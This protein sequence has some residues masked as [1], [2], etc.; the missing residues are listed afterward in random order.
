[1]QQP[2]D[3]QHHPLLLA[4][5]K[6]GLAAPED[7]APLSDR[8]RDRDDVYALKCARSG[9][10]V[11]NRTDHINAEVYE[12]RGDLSY[13]GPAERAKLLQSTLMDDA[14]RAQFIRPHVQGKSYLDIGTG[15]GGILDIVRPF[16]DEVH[17][18]EPQAGARDILLKEGYATFKHI[19]D[20]PRQHYDVV[21][22]L[23]V[24]EHVPDQIEFLASVRE[25]LKPGG[26]L[27]VEVPHARDALLSLYESPAFLNFT[28]WS[29][30]L[31]LHTRESL[32]R[33]AEQAAFSDIQVRG[34][35]RYSLANHLHWLAKNKPGGHVVWDFLNDDALSGAYERRL[36]QLDM[37]DTLLATAR[38]P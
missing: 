27:V 16:C 12:D 33:F 4:L 18:V 23:H 9:L 1:M 8:V 10:I 21:S 32:R 14:R 13:W 3:L 22:L 15:L 34:I 20:V 37:T 11:L 7:F 29:Q 17:A 38:V 25:V 28:L 35:Q 36:D 24:Y 26:F 2:P 31:I 19:N 30:H 5:Q 6:A